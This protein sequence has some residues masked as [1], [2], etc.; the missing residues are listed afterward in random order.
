MALGLG[1][2][3]SQAHTPRDFGDLPSLAPAGSPEISKV[4]KAGPLKVCHW[5]PTPALKSPLVFIPWVF[6]VC[7]LCLVLSQ[8]SP[9]DLLHIPWGGHDHTHFSEGH[10]EARGG[11]PGAGASGIVEGSNSV[12]S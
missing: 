5:G 4:S 11:S 10:T 6:W 3:P 12:P 8:V 2:S 7:A 1:V 9:F